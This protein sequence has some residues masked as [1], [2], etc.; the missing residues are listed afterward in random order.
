MMWSQGMVVS[1]DS[2]GS[3]GGLRVDADHILT[4]I[5]RLREDALAT[6]GKK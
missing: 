6:V 2:E 3:M 4:D 1:V 5:N